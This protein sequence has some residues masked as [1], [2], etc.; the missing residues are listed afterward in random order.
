MPYRRFDW[1]E[2]IAEVWGEFRSARAAV[3][4]LRA[5]VAG[6]PDLL[7]NDRVAREYLSRADEN[8]DGTY[9]V[10]LFAAFEA[11]LRSFDR[12]KRSDP[13]RETKA[14]I[15]IDEIG[16]KRGRGIQAGIRQR[17]LDVRRIRNDWA[18]EEDAVPT[19]MTV[20]EARA[21]LQAYLHELPDEWG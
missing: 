7:K 6:T 17:A 11:A 9:I 4:R 8:L 18:H 3:D 19:P 5:E 13:A 2:H 16:G 20:D 10:R 12:A 15:M 1:H 14:A 21:R